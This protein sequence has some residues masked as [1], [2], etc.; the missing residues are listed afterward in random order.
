[1]QEAEKTTLRDIS[2][3]IKKLRK[4]AGFTSHEKF[5]HYIGMDP[6]NYYNIENGANFTMT[7]LLRIT[8]GLEI[9]LCELFRNS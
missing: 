5:A 8:A 7:T 1:M 2:N 6:K 3:R 9:S 4:E